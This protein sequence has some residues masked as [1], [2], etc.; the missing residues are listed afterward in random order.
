MIVTS[1]SGPVT[2]TVHRLSCVD[3]SAPVTW[4]WKRMCSSSR[5]SRAVARTYS[6]IAGP[7]AMALAWVHGRNE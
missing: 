1:P 7:S 4:W 6:R 5:Y 2:R 3:H